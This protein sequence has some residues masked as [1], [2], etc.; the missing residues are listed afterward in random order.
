L[1]NRPVIINDDGIFRGFGSLPVEP[2][3][4]LLLSLAATL[5]QPTSKYFD[6]NRYPYHLKIRKNQLHFLKSGA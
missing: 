5:A 6:G 4:N 3:K 2:F 1:V